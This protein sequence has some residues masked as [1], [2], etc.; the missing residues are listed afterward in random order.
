ML[1]LSKLMR[2]YKLSILF[3]IR[4]ENSQRMK[5]NHAIGERNKPKITAQHKR[6][7]QIEMKFSVLDFKYVDVEQHNHRASSLLIF[8]TFRFSSVHLYQYNWIEFRIIA[9]AFDWFVGLSVYLKVGYP[10]VCIKT[11]RIVGW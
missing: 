8:I 9:V 5:W 10:F 6:P 1:V 3:N 2:L 7:I 4:F 11:R